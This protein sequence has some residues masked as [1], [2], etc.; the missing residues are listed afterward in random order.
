MPPALGLSKEQMR[1]RINARARKYRLLYPERHRAHDHKR[2]W[3]DRER[4][5]AGHKSWREKNKQKAY[6][7]SRKVLARVEAIKCANPCPDCGRMFPPECMD[8]DHRPN[9]VKVA[10][11]SKMV[12]CR[13]AWARIEAEIAKC[14]VICAC[15]HRIRTKSRHRSI[16]IGRVA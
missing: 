12:V 3:A 13:W 2:Y 4:R 11:V 9:E 7:I 10:S 14:D 15:C 8:F 5:L 16:R 6:E 1:E